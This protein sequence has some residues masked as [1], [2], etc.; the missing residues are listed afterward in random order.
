MS[1]LLSSGERRILTVLMIDIVSST[2]LAGELDP[3]DYNEI[4]DRLGQIWST[5]ITSFEGRVIKWTGDG[6]VAV[7][8]YPK[9]HNNDAIRCIAAG[10]NIL[11]SLAEERSAGLVTPDVRMGVH[12]GLILVHQVGS[13]GDFDVVGQAPAVAKRLEALA[14][15]NELL[16][17][18]ATARR[19]QTDFEL[20]SLGVRQLKGVSSEIEVWELL[21]R[22]D[23]IGFEAPVRLVGRD[24]ELAHLMDQWQLSIGAKRQAVVITAGPGMGKTRLIEELLVLIGSEGEALVLRCS[25]LMGTTALYPLIQGLRSLISAPRSTPSEEVLDRLDAEFGALPN[26]AGVALVASLIGITPRE[27]ETLPV[28]PGKRRAELWESLLDWLKLRTQRGPCCLVIEDLHWSDPSTTEFLNVLLADPALVNLFVVLTTR[29]EGSHQIAEHRDIRSIEL[30]ALT[31]DAAST[32]IEEIAGGSISDEVR[33]QLLDRSDSVPLYI[34][35]LTRA[36]T[37]AGLL[38]RRRQGL[39]LKEPLSST[40][41]PASLAD[42]LM[43]RLDSLGAARGLAS[44]AATIGRTFEAGLLSEIIDAQPGLESDLAQ[45]VNVGVLTRFDTP[46]RDHRYTFSHELLRARPTKP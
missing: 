3:E 6:C 4:L 27:T 35:E 15:A 38:E 46:G 12:T 36:V 21:G 41:I 45:M 9:A 26:P 34:T 17:S 22:R 14:P 1:D 40:D 24:I 5:T 11:E 29:L 39:E 8:G 33:R 20:R 37:E 23:D 42:S 31:E 43:M 32:M 7:F 2:S 25:E 13:S 28:E 30:G 16:M 44:A 18:G 19:V 10:L